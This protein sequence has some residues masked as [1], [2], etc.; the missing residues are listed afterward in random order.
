MWNFKLGNENFELKI[1]DLGFE[2]FEF[3]SES[4]I[5]NPLQEFSFLSLVFGNQYNPSL[6]MISFQKKKR[7]EKKRRKRKEKEKDFFFLGVELVN[8]IE[9]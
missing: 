4:F 1:W 7:K 8:S 2:N 5:L 3:E 6:F 9:F